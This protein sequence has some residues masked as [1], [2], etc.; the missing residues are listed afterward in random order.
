MSSSERPAQVRHVEV[1]EAR[2]GQR[3]DN[4]LMSQLAG[5]P[6]SVIYRLI[7]TG[8]VRV[9]GK[10]AKPMAKLAAGDQV[11]V[12]PV[13]QDRAARPRVPDEV[14]TQLEAAVLYDDQGLLALDK[15]CGLAVHAGSGV[16]WGVVD[17]LRQSRQDD[18]IGLVHRLDRETSGLLLLAKDPASLKRAQAQFRERSTTKK[19]F[20]LLEGRLPQ[21]LLEVDE[22]LIKTQRGGERYMVVDP[23][24]KR[25]VTRFRVLEAF[26]G[27][28]FVEAEPI[29]GRTH[30]I[31]AHA[32][33]LGAPCAGDPR[34]SDAASLAAWKRRGLER[35]FLHA[36]ALTLDDAR[37]ERLHLSCPLPAELAGV[38]DGH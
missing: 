2:A 14:V 16:R 12:P 11:R 38:L 23:A 26:P 18:D 37:G 20:A 21:E 31:R 15:P 19:Y 7:R 24:G 9:N 17:A 13:R 8:Q 36:H 25:A 1:P 35:L 27:S 6:R 33:F 3:L 22:P 4:F 32:A 28:V 10:R 34:Y 29:T 5:V 30:Q